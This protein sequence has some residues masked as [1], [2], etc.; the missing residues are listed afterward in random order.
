MSTEVARE[1]K[2]TQG[3]ETRGLTHVKQLPAIDPKHVGQPNALSR[4]IL[5]VLDDPDCSL[6][7]THVVN[8]PRPAHL[9]AVP[10]GGAAARSRSGH[11]Q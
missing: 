10:A 9:V 6:A 1:K 8:T 11:A 7:A 2:L 3:A 4:L 5:A